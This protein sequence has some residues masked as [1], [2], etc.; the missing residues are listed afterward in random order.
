MSRAD[1]V[2]QT[3]RH[4][5]DGAHRRGT[6]RRCQ[7]LGKSDPITRHVHLLTLWTFLPADAARITTLPDGS[8]RAWRESLSADL[9]HLYALRGAPAGQDGN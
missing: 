1:P 6:L 5:I 8:A 2:T 3:A 4:H 9:S 7:Y